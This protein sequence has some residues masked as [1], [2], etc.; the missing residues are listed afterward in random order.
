MNLNNLLTV[1]LYTKSDIRFEDLIF[2]N[3]GLAVHFQKWCRAVTPFKL[4]LEDN[5]HA[6]SMSTFSRS[7]SS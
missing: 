6:Y 3:N 1:E 2:I 4:S 5:T 7:M